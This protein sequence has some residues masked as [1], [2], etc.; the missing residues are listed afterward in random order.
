MPVTL[1]VTGC[2]V[3]RTED[4]TCAKAVSAVRIMTGAMIPEGADCV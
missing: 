2:V 4:G 1:E 3:C